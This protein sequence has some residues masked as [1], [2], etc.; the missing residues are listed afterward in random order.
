MAGGGGG[1]AMVVRLGG[2]RFLICKSGCN[3]P[4]NKSP[5]MQAII[6]KI[7]AC[8]EGDVPSLLSNPLPGYRT[9]R[10]R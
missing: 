5:P 6:F 4:F 1:W 2:V 10:D 3:L 9:M 7:I 8:G